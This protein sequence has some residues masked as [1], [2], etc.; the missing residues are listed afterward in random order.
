MILTKN[1]EKILRAAAKLFAEKGFDRTSLKDISKVCRWSQGNIYNYF[2]TKEGILYQVLLQEMTVL[3]DKV[4]PIAEDHAL[5]PVEQ[6]KL[7]VETH[8]QYAV[9]PP[10]GKM[11][12]FEFEMRHIKPRHRAEIIRL[13]DVYDGILE[14]I[15]QRGMDEGV[16]GGVD[17]KM[18]GY[19]ISA[20]IERV[21]LW[22]SPKGKLSSLEIAE[23]LSTVFLNG[24]L[25]EQAED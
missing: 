13:R 10:V 9:R 17:K 21:R 3:V 7:L 18:A 22:Y 16:F 8:V 19:T 11:L 2:K 6:L 12:Y 1:H 23:R 25:A 24:L 5:S 4:Q 20:A 15:I 14:E